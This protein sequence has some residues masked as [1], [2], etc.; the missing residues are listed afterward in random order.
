MKRPMIWTAA[1][2][3][4]GGLLGWL[5]ANGKLANVFA[6]QKKTAEPM[7]DFPRTILPIPEPTIPQSTMVD[8]TKTW[9]CAERKRSEIW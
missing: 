5:T 1:V 9:Q 4:V 7:A 2:L 6:H 3:A 8:L